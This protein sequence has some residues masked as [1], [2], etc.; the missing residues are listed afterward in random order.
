M[1]KKI[2]P[3]VVSL[4]LSLG[5]GGLSAWLTRDSM[6][7]Y[8][9]LNQPPLAPPAEVFPWVWSILFVLMGLA[10]ALVWCSNGRTIDNSII[11]YGVQLVMNFV[12]TLI[13]FNFGA[14]LLAFV[15]LLLLLVLIVLTAASF[16]KVKPLAGVLMIPYA[17]W[18]AFAGY[19][20]LM[21]Y[22]LNR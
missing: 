4:A 16:Y 18:V 21:I 7:I 20:N 22:L 17:L 6:E 2:Y 8:K 14:Y 15:W 19:L 10:A 5:V 11:L 9:G 3:Y 12:W 13:F 1:W